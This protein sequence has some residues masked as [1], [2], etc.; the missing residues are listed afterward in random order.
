MALNTSL[1]SSSQLQPEVATLRLRLKQLN[2]WPVAGDKFLMLL[3]Q[4]RTQPVRLTPDDNEWIKMVA[5][6]A[7]R[8]CDIGARYPAFF[9]KLLHC[10]DLLKAFLDELDQQQNY[11][12]DA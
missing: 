12:H 11:W 10:P 9:H 2:V 5:K 4:T 6:D 8:A 7:L 3:A 1:N